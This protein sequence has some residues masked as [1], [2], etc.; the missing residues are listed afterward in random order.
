MNH[1][2]GQS[3]PVAVTRVVA[4]IETMNN[5][6]TVCKQHVSTTNL[7]AIMLTESEYSH[8]CVRL[9]SEI[10]LCHPASV[11]LLIALACCP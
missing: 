10:M 9:K 4:Y 11:N 3:H 8:G 2:I 7:N 6:C 5:T 1:R